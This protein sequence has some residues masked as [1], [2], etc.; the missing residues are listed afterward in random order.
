M[1]QPRL[2]DAR[3]LRGFE[4]GRGVG[5]TGTEVPPSRPPSLGRPHCEPA[6]T[7]PLHTAT[8][9]RSRARAGDRD[10]L[11]GPGDRLGWLW[12]TPVEI[13]C[14]DRSEGL[15]R[16]HSGAS[17]RSRYRASISPQAVHTDPP[18]SGRLRHCRLV[19]GGARRPRLGASRFVSP[20]GLLLTS[21]PLPP[22][23]M[24]A[25]TTGA[26]CPLWPM[27]RAG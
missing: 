9:P 18:D 22:P 10:R 23:L 24:N 20:A 26:V 25:L 5:R 19:S 12:I 6:Y 15:S 17:N 3:R 21:E 27:E 13:S 4:G 16:G 11:E 1:R 7:V 14:G 8:S 2:G